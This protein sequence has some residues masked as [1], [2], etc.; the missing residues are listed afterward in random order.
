MYATP[1]SGKSYIANK[2]QDVV[3][4]DD[5]M[6]D[7]IQ[8]LTPS[9]CLP[10]YNDSRQV[11]FKYFKFIKFNRR[12]MNILYRELIAKMQYH[13]GINDVVLLGTMDLMHVADRIF[14]E[15]NSDIVRSGFTDKQD[16]EQDKADDEE[17]YNQ[18]AVHYIHEYLEKSMMRLVRNGEV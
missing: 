7:A 1:G 3:D 17:S 2:Y 12:K 15:N 4:A 14:I 9:F 5:L 6:V 10:N 13:T 16:R 18:K 8:E 11:I